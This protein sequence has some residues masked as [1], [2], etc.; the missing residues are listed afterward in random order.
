MRIENSD[1]SIKSVCGTFC[2][3]IVLAV[4]LMYAIQKLKVLDSR[5]D[6]RIRTA[7]KDLYFSDEDQ[8]S[9]NEHKFNVA[10]AFTAYNNN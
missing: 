6:I 7:V 1:S 9:F 10:V 3:L 8:F 5:T 4:T 2:S